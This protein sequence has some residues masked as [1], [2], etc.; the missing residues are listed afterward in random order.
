MANLDTAVAVGEREG[1][2]HPMTVI[3]PSE[4]TG[5]FSTIGYLMAYCAN[6]LYVMP[7]LPSIAVGVLT[8]MVAFAVWVGRVDR[9]TRVG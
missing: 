5:V 9:P 7:V 4:Q 3:L 8:G 2:T 1:L 6:N